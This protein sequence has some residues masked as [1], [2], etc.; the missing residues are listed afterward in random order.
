[1]RYVCTSAPVYLSASRRPASIQHPASPVHASNLQPPR[2][3]PDTHPQ[4]T[5]LSPY[6]KA[7]HPPSPECSLLSVDWQQHRNKPP[8][9]HTPSSRAAADIS[10]LVDASE[11][12]VSAAAPM[13]G[14]GSALRTI[15]LWTCK[16]DKGWVGTKHGPGV[17]SRCKCHVRARRSSTVSRITPTSARCDEFKLAWSS[18][19]GCPCFD[20]ALVQP[21]P[22][23]TAKA[24]PAF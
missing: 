22:D 11:G 6:Y 9:S 8:T 23:T 15:S 13:A 3:R 21:R 14:I 19:V 4:E 20:A 10:T 5:T 18:Q 2:P 7:Y 24:R 1:L 16:S 17:K 12:H